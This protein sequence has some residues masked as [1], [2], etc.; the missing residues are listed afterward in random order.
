MASS[1][2]NVVRVATRK[3]VPISLPKHSLPYPLVYRR[4]CCHLNPK[5]IFRQLFDGKSSTYTYI[6]ADAESKE[7]MII[8]PV[9]EQVD[10]DVEL[11]QQLGLNLKY[12]LN[13]HVH[14]D[15]ITGTGLLKQHCNCKTVISS[16]S[17]AKADI[18]L[19]H[20]DKISV[21]NV[22]LEVRSTPGH[23]NG[24]VS[25]VCPTLGAAFTGDALLI[26]GCGR[27]DFQQGSSEKLYESVH[28]QIF[29]LPDSTYL[30]P[31]HDYKG[32]TVTTVAEEKAF[33]PRLSKSITEFVAI[34]AALNLP[35]PQMIDKA[36]PANMVCGL[37]G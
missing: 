23:T 18:H 30:Y 35:Q 17:E 20:Q 24:C 4:F 13:T 34:M 31:A 7:A 21:G 1:V 25:Y 6:V 12:A 3:T 8:D 32:Q 15:H 19:K 37:H 2:L 27:T 33:N 28:S 5:D 14:A 16:Y 10:R 11:L 29:S 9:L 22:E 26:R 36:V